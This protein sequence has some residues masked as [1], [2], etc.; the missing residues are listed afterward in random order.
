MF[1]FFFNEEG[2]I[3]WKSKNS[4]LPNLP[5]TALIHLRKKHTAR[6]KFLIR[7]YWSLK[8]SLFLL[9]ITRS[10]REQIMFY[11]KTPL[12]ALAGSQMYS[13]LQFRKYSKLLTRH[14]VKSSFPKCYNCEGH[15]T[16]SPSE[17]KLFILVDV[18]L[19]CTTFVSSCRFPTSTACLWMWSQSWRT[20][21]TT[22]GTQEESAISPGVTLQIPTYAGSTAPCRSVGRKA[23]QQVLPSAI[24]CPLFLFHQLNF[25]LLTLSSASAA[26][27]LFQSMNLVF[28]GPKLIEI[29]FPTTNLFFFLLGSILIY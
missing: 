12:S 22:V 26:N 15:S 8:T 17:T 5:G 24:F 9:Q 1:F 14:E 16:S 13:P 18:F 23:R 25:W 3:S 10:A 19:L 28:Q 29:N 4:V 20:Q 6:K 11:S 7:L 27:Y 2:E 21:T